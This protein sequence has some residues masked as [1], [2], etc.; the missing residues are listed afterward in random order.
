MVVMHC[1]L[2]CFVSSKTQMGDMLS[3]KKMLHVFFAGSFGLFGA[4]KQQQ[5]A[6]F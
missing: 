3:L 4:H 6:V 1:F 5:R 2:T